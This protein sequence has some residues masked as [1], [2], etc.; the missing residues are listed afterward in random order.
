ML[1]F[2]FSSYCDHIWS[3]YNN[4]IVKIDNMVVHIVT[5]RGQ[6]CY[7]T[8]SIVLQYY[9]FFTIWWMIL[10]TYCDKNSLQPF[11]CPIWPISTIIVILTDRS[12]LVTSNNSHT[13]FML[14][15]SIVIIY[16]SG[17]SKMRTTFRGPLSIW[18]DT[19]PTTDIEQ[20]CGVHGT[21]PRLWLKKK[22]PRYVDI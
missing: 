5:I 16:I 2:P 20:V 15:A 4:R 9:V 21:S 22:R 1:S 7:N 19:T 10:L 14:A 11:L 17:R 13:L 12:V 18:Y 6:C 3:T 8:V